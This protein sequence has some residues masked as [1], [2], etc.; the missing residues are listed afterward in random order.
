M[1]VCLSLFIHFDFPLPCSRIPI[2]STQYEVPETRIDQMRLFVQ[3]IPPPHTARWFTAQRWKHKTRTT[4]SGSC[5]VHCGSVM[6]MLP[7]NKQHDIVFSMQITLC[8]VW[9]LDTFPSV[10][11]ATVLFSCLS[12]KAPTNHFGVDCINETS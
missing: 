11:I 12:I 4:V 10:Q 1:T 9:A 2:N 7:L 3:C 5:P 6:E 8:L